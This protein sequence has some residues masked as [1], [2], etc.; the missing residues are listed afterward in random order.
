AYGISIALFGAVLLA[1]TVLV[2]PAG[3]TA[4]QAHLPALVLAALALALA[5]ASDNVSAIFRTTILQTAVPDA[6]RG[7]LQG[8]FTVV[9]TGGPR[10]G[11]LYA[12]VFAT[13]VAL[14][15]P[16]LLGGLVIV[17]L[18]VTLAR[19]YRGFR[20]YDAQDPRP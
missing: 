18:M 8:V 5:G 7:R 19:V 1:Q 6:M 10:L 3:I 16:P 13:A 14:W 17:A 9:V 4:A 15:F 20:G 11:D 12:G 2:G